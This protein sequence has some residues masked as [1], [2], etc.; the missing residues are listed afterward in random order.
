LNEQNKNC[1]KEQQF[2]QIEK[3][4]TAIEAEEVERIKSEAE[5][6]LRQAQPACD[7]AQ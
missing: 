2:I 6:Q 4:K 1:E 5:E 3:E 7:A